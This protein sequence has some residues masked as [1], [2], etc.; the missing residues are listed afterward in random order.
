MK[1]ILSIL[2]MLLLGALGAQAQAPA[3]FNYQG[4]ARN[5]VGNVLVNKNITLRLTVH[6]GTAAGPVVYQESRAVTTNPFGLFNVQVG[7]PGGTSVT[8]TIAGVNWGVGNKYIQVEIDPNGGTTF[9]NIGTAQMASV[10]YAWYT[11]LAGDLVLPFDKTQAD[12]GTLFRITNS[13]TGAG[14]TAL[15]GRTNS[16]AN[17]VSAIIGTVTPTGPGGF[18][19]GVRGINNGTGGLG[20]GVW[21]SQNG[22]GWGVY[23]QTPSG[24]GV[25]GAS[26]SGFGLYGSSTSGT[27]V[28]GL[29]TSGRSGF[30]E[31]TNAANTSVTL[32]AASNGTGWAGQFSSTNATTRALR[33]V[34]GLQ[35][36]GINE[37]LNRILASDATGNATWQDAAAVGIVTG[38]GTLN[39]VPKWTP[40]GTNLGNSELFDNGSIVGLG[41]TTPFNTQL[42]IAN[43]GIGANGFSATRYTNPGSAAAFGGLYVGLINATGSQE[44]YVGTN[45]NT[46]LGFWTS[47]LNRINITNTGQVGVGIFAPSAR[48]HAVGTGPSYTPLGTVQS[49]QTALLAENNNASGAGNAGLVAF[50]NGST[51]Y[52][53]GVFGVAG[54]SGTS[55]NIGVGGIANAASTGANYGIVGFAQNG[56]SNFAA[57][58]FGKTQIQDGT[59]GLNRVFV[60]DAVGTGSWVPIGAIGGV[61]GSGTLNYLPKWTPDGFTLGNS[62]VRDNANTIL[63]GANAFFDPVS[64]VVSNTPGSGVNSTVAMQTG[65]GL[66]QASG[67]FLEDASGKLHV[68]MNGYDV[69][70]GAKLMTFDDDGIQ[71]VGVGTVSPMGKLHTGSV[72][73]LAY[74]VPSIV[75]VRSANIAEQTSTGGLSSGI[76]AYADG[77]SGENYGVFGVSGGSSSV[78]M[79]G[80]FLAQTASTGMNI[81]ILSRASGGTTNL[82]AWLQGTVRITDGTQG[83]NRIFTSDAGGNGSWQDASAVGI[84]SGSGTLNQVAKWTPDGV[85]LGN[86]QIVDDGNTVS[87]GSTSLLGNSLSIF[88][89]PGSSEPSLFLGSGQYGGIY[90]EQATGRMHF[91]ANFSTVTG[92]NVLMTLDDDQFAV[93]IGTVS[94]IAKLEARNY[95]STLNSFTSASGFVGSTGI[96]SMDVNAEAG[97]KTGIYS[98]VDGATGS[99]LSVWAESGTTS[100]IANAALYGRV[101]A[102]PTGTGPA[103]GL[104]VLDAIGGPNT[105]AARINGRLSYQDG[106]QGAGKVL[107]SDASGNASW[108]DLIT[109]NVGIGLQYLSGTVSLPSNTTV[110]ITQWS[111]ITHETGGANYNPITGEYAITVA[112]VYQINASLAFQAT[113]T[114]AIDLIL[115]N[116][117]SSISEATGYIEPNGFSFGLNVNV[118]RHLNV[119]DLIRVDA[120]QN[121]GASLDLQSGFVSN[122]FSVQLI[123][124]D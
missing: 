52:N 89:T 105:W 62:Q 59:E 36:T 76:T 22:S 69:T 19:A 2:G 122:N 25:Y 94:P 3:I 47:S 43:D 78:N 81:G 29:S 44:A 72:H 23:G 111:T 46:N 33:T 113:G 38:S 45:E 5:S 124:K 66:G 70:S 101:S 64:I 50:A 96:A 10:P 13:G 104:F 68:T 100:N 112:G 121:T 35:L 98:F 75:A 24:I 93:G 28:Y 49:H 86:S 110:P 84:V 21:G 123:K 97:F 71:G 99:N 58:F 95:T 119:G 65:N 32:S 80:I 6:D 91:T 34:G 118:L 26:T 77:G 90:L 20:I 8:G 31:N 55:F 9:I 109:P 85:T 82:S 42:H 63:L 88:P 114:G 1:K 30:F 16:T 17:S 39:F 12:A 11:N 61:S 37:A 15:E 107:T 4:V 7:S 116:N 102:A 74:A 41:T 14:S 67:L 51:S 87:V 60:S 54:G 106:T 103:S 18:S 57:A 108:Q 27:A 40:N 48:L 120:L 73:D 83:L 53:R 92:G 56:A 117:G 79:G 115:R